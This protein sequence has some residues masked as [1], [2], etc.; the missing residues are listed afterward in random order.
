MKTMGSRKLVLSGALAA[1]LMFGAGAAGAAVLYDQQPADGEISYYAAP[2]IG[3]QLADDFTLA[4]TS[5]ITQVSWWGGYDG[6]LDAGDDGFRVRLYGDVTGT[7]SVLH[8]FTSVSAV[9]TASTLT[10]FVS[11]AIYKYTFSLPTAV[12]LGVGSYFLFVENLG[13]SDWIWLTSATGDNSLVYRGG[14]VDNWIAFDDDLAFEIEGSR[15]TTPVSEPGTLALLGLA[16]L[17]GLL[18]RRRRR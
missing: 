16:G 17:G 6:N 7:G 9:R 4:F 12:Q 8:E 15:V 3:Q 2:S 10:D 1:T 5:D 11:N 13:S 14:D 18:A